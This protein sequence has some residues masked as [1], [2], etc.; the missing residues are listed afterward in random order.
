MRLE[1]Y[2]LGCRQNRSGANGQREAQSRRETEG[3]G[4]HCVG[5]FCIE[6]EGKDRGLIIKESDCR[7]NG[8]NDR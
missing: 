1:T 4:K 8:K 7:K 2:Q 3:V 6:L 5:R